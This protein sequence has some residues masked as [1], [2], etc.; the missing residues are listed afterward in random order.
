MVVFGPSR[1]KDHHAYD[2]NHSLGCGAEP[3]HDQAVAPVLGG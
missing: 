1:P 3:G 2:L